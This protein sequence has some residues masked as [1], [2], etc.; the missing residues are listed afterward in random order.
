MAANDLPSLPPSLVDSYRQYKDLTSSFTTWLASTGEKYGFRLSACKPATTHTPEPSTH[1][2]NPRLKGKA[3]KLARDADK[4]AQNTKSLTKTLLLKDYIPLAK[5]IVSSTKSPQYIP[6]SVLTKLQ[7]AIDL[8]RRFA[9]W[10]K[11]GAQSTA[12]LMSNGSHEHFIKVLNTV[13]DILKPLCNQSTAS[14]QGQHST[15]TV[16]NGRR[17]DSAEP[18]LTL[19]NQFGA[20]TVETLEN[21]QEE[22]ENLSQRTTS[23]KQVRNSSLTTTLY[24]PEQQPPDDEFML[25]CFC[26]FQDLQEVRSSLQETWQKYKDRR[27]TLITASLITNTALDFVR[28]A[29]LI[30]KTTFS[31]TGDYYDTFVDG[32]F[33]QACAGQGHPFVAKRDFCVKHDNL[34]ETQPYVDEISSEAEW[35][36]LP[37]WHLLQHCTKLLLLDPNGAP[38]ALPAHPAPEDHLIKAW[39]FNGSDTAHANRRKHQ[40]FNGVLLGIAM[41]TFKNQFDNVGVDQFREGLFETLHTKMIP[42]WLVFA[43]QNFLDIQHIL[44]QDV[45]R[46]RQDFNLTFAIIRDRVQQHINHLEPLAAQNTLEGRDFRAFEYCRLRFFGHKVQDLQTVFL[47]NPVGAGLREFFT[48]AWSRNMG[49]YSPN[50]SDVIAMAHLYHVSR[51]QSQCATWTDMEFVIGVQTPEHVFL[52][53]RPLTFEQCWRKAELSW[54]LSMRNYLSTSATPNPIIRP[55]SNL[56]MLDQDDIPVTN[57]F[58]ARGLTPQARDIERTTENLETVLTAALHG[59][60]RGKFRQDDDGKLINRSE[61]LKRTSRMPRATM[62][63]LLLV[64]EENLVREETALHFDYYGFRIVCCNLL[65]DIARQIRP[66]WIHATGTEP[67]D[68]GLPT[69]L[70]IYQIL[71]IARWGLALS[72]DMGVPHFESRVFNE[73]T[74]M[75]EDHTIPHGSRLVGKLQHFASG[76]LL[77]AAYTARFGEPTSEQ[78]GSSSAP[79]PTLTSMTEEEVQRARQAAD[80]AHGLHSLASSDVRGRRGR[81]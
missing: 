30:F 78:G 33:R 63:Q 34:H 61:L 9:S 26:F 76:A 8:R 50:S 17:R 31:R 18:Q 29:E 67:Y 15:T 2:A 58:F 11:T 21:E 45:I 71:N 25:G 28:K 16:G 5:H 35:I 54:G 38:C 12:S 14:G 7:R 53:G 23:A 49:T 73:V 6:S 19:Y 41:N 43:T 20:L 65:K 24:I 1:K 55:G 47:L 56:R 10:F 59:V 36:M 77:W 42:A 37:S 80:G 51:L 60:D 57:I 3:R 48:I 72:V 27:V 74:G 75:L 69:Q 22:V 79:R 70:L 52:G 66:V 68:G 39:R 44:K 13:L 46:G 64:L 62:S 32:A 81:R 40:I 4:T